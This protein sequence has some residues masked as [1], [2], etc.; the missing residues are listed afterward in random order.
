M[1]ISLSQLFK[2]LNRVYE[3]PQDL[4]FT[5]IS[6]VLSQQPSLADYPQ[7]EL[8]ALFQMC[9]AF[10]CK[11]ENFKHEV[12]STCTSLNDTSSGKSSL[13]VQLPCLCIPN[14]CIS[15]SQHLSH[16]FGFALLPLGLQ[17]TFLE[18]RDCVCLI[19]DLFM[20]K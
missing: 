13:E 11:L 19:L 10:F 15:Q 4:F 2:I 18:G 6:R 14:T 12:P 7:T 9:F 17:Q 20:C 16:H 1:S 8:L 5:Y 3:A